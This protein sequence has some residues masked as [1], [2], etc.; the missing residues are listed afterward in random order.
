MRREKGV[1]AW[2][3]CRTKTIYLWICKYCVMGSCYLMCIRIK[4]HRLHR[5]ESG[6]GHCFSGY[7]RLNIPWEP[8][9]AHLGQTWRTLFIEIT[10]SEMTVTIVSL[11]KGAE[12]ILL[13][14]SILSFQMMQGCTRLVLSWKTQKKLYSSL[15]AFFVPWELSWVPSSGGWLL[16]WHCILMKFAGNK[17]KTGKSMA[18]TLNLVKCVQ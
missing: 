8:G 5:P 14:S 9:S 2:M 6:R 7:T 10:S 17:W 13:V 18:M 3:F 1:P 12:D 16:T 11:T 4:Q 15:S